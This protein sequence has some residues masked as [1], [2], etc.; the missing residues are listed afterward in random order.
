M[1]AAAET[2]VSPDT[3]FQTAM[4]FMAAKHLFVANELGLF[5]TLADGPATL[6]ELAAG[7]GAPTRT[8]RIVADA[9]VALGFLDKDGTAYRNGEVAASFLTGRGPMDAAPLLRFWN[10]IS[11]PAWASLERAARTD[12]AVRG[13]LTEEQQEIFSEGVEAFTAGAAH[14]LA[15]AYDFSRHER[16]LDVGGGTGS[17]LVAAITPFP[18]VRGTLFELPDVAEI[19]REKLAASPVSGRVDAV[20]GDV[21][22]DELPAGH[23]CVLLANVVHYFLPERNVELL[24]RIRRAVEP[25]ARV[26]LVDFWTNATH[27]EPLPAVLIAGEFLSLVGGDV[28]SRDELAEWLAETGW[29]WIETLPLPGGQS[30]VVAEAC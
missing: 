30:A 17:F 20:G 25:G 16:V 27:T 29:S 3:I 28:Y 13:E 11:Y 19:A 1:G 24:R 18:G 6:E 26:V 10:A 21:L 8:V 2:R 9:M 14:A 15:A 7:A 5:R 4:G 22:A 23:D 12:E